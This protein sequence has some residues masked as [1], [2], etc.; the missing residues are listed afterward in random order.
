MTSHLVTL[1]GMFGLLVFVFLLFGALGGG[2]LAAV[3]TALA[4]LCSLP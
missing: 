3:L 4:R 2:A 1:R